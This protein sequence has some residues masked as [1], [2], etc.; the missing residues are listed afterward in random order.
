MAGTGDY[1]IPFGV[2]A[3][4][5]FEGLNKM[6]QGVEQLTTNVVQSQ[7]EMQGAFTTAANAG[8]VLGKRLDTTT[9]KALGLRDQAKTLG[10]DLGAALSGNNAGQGLED[11]LNKIKKLMDTGAGKG[12]KLKFDIDTAKLE[13]FE[14]MLTDGQDE[15]KVLAQ[16]V[17]YAKGKLATLAPN[18]PEFNELSQQIETADAL[19]KAFGETNDLVNTKNKSLKSQLRQMKEELALMETQ[20]KENTREFLNLSV[21]AGKVEDQIGDISNRVRVL[22]S[23]T[24]YIDAGIQAVTG[25]AGAFAAAQGAAAL[26]GSEN[27]EV[28]RVIQKVTGAMAILQGIQAVANALN[29]DSALSVLFLSRSQTQGGGIYGGTGSC[30]NSGSRGNRDCHSSHARPDC[31]PFSQP[32]NFNY[33]RI[34]CSG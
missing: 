21:A 19:L 6:D 32:G 16:V 31:S 9:Q 5:F 10:K 14:K 3:R 13:Q 7:K 18:T 8:D 33:Y 20:G 23:D 29:K 17:D 25:L 11:R 4:P 28:N 30:R 2:D 1:L 22:A 34:D 12:V 24:K 27:E 15:L 26:F